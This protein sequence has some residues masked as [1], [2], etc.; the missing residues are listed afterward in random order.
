[1]NDI[2][3]NQIHSRLSRHTWLLGAAAILGIAASI[4]WRELSEFAHFLQIKNA[5]GL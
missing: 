1:M 5:L 2:N 4:Y 3:A